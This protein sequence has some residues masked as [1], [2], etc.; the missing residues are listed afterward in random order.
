MLGGENA[1]A[2]SPATGGRSTP[3]KFQAL[4]DALLSAMGETDDAKKAKS[5]IENGLMGIV[6]N[7]LNP[8]AAADNSGNG[9][10]VSICGDSKLEDLVSGI[11]G[12]LEGFGLLNYE[13]DEV[14]LPKGLRTILE[15]ALS[16]MT[17]EGAAGTAETAPAEGT[18]SAPANGTEIAA[19]S[20]PSDDYARM[21]NG[22][23]ADSIPLN[24]QKEIV[25]LV[26]EYL[27][28]FANSNNNGATDEAAEKAASSTAIPAEIPGTADAVKAVMQPET[29]LNAENPDADAP[30]ADEK[31]PK[32]IADRI[33]QLLKTSV[34]EAKGAKA[35]EPAA[36]D[37]SATAKPDDA[38]NTQT[39]ELGAAYAQ[40]QPAAANTGK[41]R[42]FE[43]EPR[44]TARD[45]AD[46]V[47]KIVDK[48]TTQLKE[49][50]REFEV[51]L[52]PEHLGK[53]SITLLLDSDGI[54]ANLKAADASVKSMIANELP[55]LQDML[56]EKGLN[57]VKI[58]VAYDNPT[59]D[60]SGG[61]FRQNREDGNPRG[62]QNYRNTE[63][64]AYGLSFDAVYETDLML[65]NS[66]VEFQA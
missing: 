19:G 49:G 37:D 35:A 53:L 28:S 23:Q 27:C 42:T 46:N 50:Q 38:Q 26:A 5:G 62:K 1:V 20:T 34:E 13:T 54:K 40:K 55:V 24:A 47:A 9:Q 63:L 16:Q 56:R 45:M 52:K 12:I 6:M 32:G 60:A 29:G 4:Q 10:K 64:P 3:G 39:Q 17:P 58:D 57:V 31:T 65:R 30:K 43:A 14:T 44:A 25:K 22:G 41:V 21:P 61:S 51:T 66:S 33:M 59:F 11:A 48:I 15:N 7:L 8:N 36:K 18:A 2:V